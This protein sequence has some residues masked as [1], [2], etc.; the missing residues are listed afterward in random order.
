MHRDYNKLIRDRIPEIIQ[1]SGKCCAV[2]TMSEAEY[3][4][5]LLEK[6][7]E[8]AQEACRAAPEELATELADL[9]EVIA[10]VLAAWHISPEKVQQIQDQRRAERGGFEQQLKLLWTEEGDEDV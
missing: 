10:A 8:E 1:N 9:Q 5:A 6:L 2:E 7:V 3:R 4:Q